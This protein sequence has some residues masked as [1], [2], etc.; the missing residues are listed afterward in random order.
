MHAARTLEVSAG[1]RLAATVR[2][3]FCARPCLRFAQGSSRMNIRRAVLIF[4]AA[5]AAASCSEKA[6]PDGNKDS[7]TPEPVRSAT[8]EPQ[9]GKAETEDELQPSEDEIGED[10]VA[11]LRATK[12]IPAQ[13]T[14]AEC[15]ACSAEGTE[16]FAFRE[17]KTDHVFCS[18]GTCEVAVTIRASFNPSAGGRITGGLT[19]WILPEQQSDY[20]SG[21]P[22]S[23]EQAYRV[24]IT[25][26]RTGEAWRAI[27][28]DRADPE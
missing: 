17:M 10:C 13:T 28:F 12:V 11:F 14:A 16:V 20:L 22:G 15:P 7:N 9:P 4:V 2:K 26:K 24:K 1:G 23:G 21:H 3:Q 8:R 6:A 18:S 19:A 27:E 25:Y 5:V